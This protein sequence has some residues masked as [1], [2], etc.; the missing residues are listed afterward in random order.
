MAIVNKR[1]LQKILHPH[2]L[3][4]LVLALSFLILKNVPPFCSFLFEVCELDYV[5]IVQDFTISLIMITL[6]GNRDPVLH[7]RHHHVSHSKTR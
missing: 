4:N 1:E 2:Y 6:E 5:S 3:V 7:G